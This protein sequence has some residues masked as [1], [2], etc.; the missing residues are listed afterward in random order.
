MYKIKYNYFQFLILLI[1]LGCAFF[2]RYLSL[3]EFTFNTDELNH[4][5][6]AKSILLCGKPLLPSGEQYNRALCFTYLCALS[7]KIFHT[8][9]AVRYFSLL[10]GLLTIFVLFILCRK[11]FGSM[12]AFIVATLLT[13]SPDSIILSFYC[14]MYAMQQFLYLAMIYVGFKWLEYNTSNDFFSLFKPMRRFVWLCV[15]LF[16]FVLAVHIQILSATIL[17]VFWMYCFVMAIIVFIQQGMLQL[18]KNKY[19]A[20]IGISFLLVLA[21]LFYDY[22]F[23]YKIYHNCTTSLSWAKADTNNIRFYYH[24]FKHKYTLLWILYPLCLVIFL[25]DERNKKK[26]ILIA[27]SFVVPFMVH[28][29][30]FA[31]K[32]QRYI[33][34]ILPYL[35]IP[36]AYV[37]TLLT[38]WLKK[39]FILLIGENIFAYSGLC[40]SLFIILGWTIYSE[41]NSFIRYAVKIPHYLYDN[42]VNI[43]FPKWQKFINVINKQHNSD[44]IIL[45]YDPLSAYYYLGRIDY[46]INNYKTDLGV[47]VK[48]VDGNYYYKDFYCGSRYVDSVDELKKIV[49][50]HKSGWIILRYKIRSRDSFSELVMY[51]HRFMYRHKK[52]TGCYFL[53]SWGHDE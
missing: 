1:I 14:R 52:I 19:T 2:I 15:F 29:L 24:V 53:Y 6:S 23:I 37:L 21:M 20:L 22:S 47:K 51:I 13:L 38:Q 9:I 26:S 11:W 25:L 18:A 39:R 16:V 32:T 33:F 28:S 42:Y 4:L 36:I 49:A 27:L 10:F 34:Y 40:I 17:V 5:Y 31:T 35:L 44:D 30:F 43:V 48:S 12:C 3:Q 50:M 45:S 8:D 7:L 46:T 41:E